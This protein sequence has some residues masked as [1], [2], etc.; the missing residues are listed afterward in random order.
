MAELLSFNEFIDTTASA[1]IDPH[2]GTLRAASAMSRPAA[3]AAPVDAAAFG[4][5][6]KG[7]EMDR[8]EAEFSRMKAYVLDYY[9]NGKIKPKRSFLGLGDH[10]IDCIP[11]ED[12]PGI[13]GAKKAKHQIQ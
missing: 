7:E 11:F 10:P 5:A 6:P 1:K 2:L 9:N 12:Q 4:L 8:L 13:R 3:M